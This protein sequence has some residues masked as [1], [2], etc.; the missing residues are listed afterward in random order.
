MTPSHS[1]FSMSLP[2][3]EFA[4]RALIVYAFLLTV[5]RISGKRQVAQLSPFDFV[6][7]LVLS[8]AVQNSMNGGDN[9]LVGGL[10]SALTLVLINFALG[11]AVFRSRKIA[12]V[13][14]GHLEIL[15]HDGVL[16][17][18]ALLRQKLTEQ[19]LE[20]AMRI[21]GIEDIKDIRLAILETNGHISVI[22]R[23]EKA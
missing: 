4:L 19:D 14:E 13:V 17:R 8:N 20:S 16:Y 5:L 9:S 21:A 18:Q 7:L 23:E 3:W 12:H 2:W 10:V 6:L 11:Y 22:R 15:V 1:L